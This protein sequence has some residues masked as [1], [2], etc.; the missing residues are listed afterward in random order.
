MS[1]AKSFLRVTQLIG[2]A[3]FAYILASLDLRQVFH[4]LQQ[5]RLEWVAAYAGL[6]AIS[7]TAKGL[8]WNACLKSQKAD[9][10]V[11]RVLGI[12]FVASFVGAVTPG[13]IGEVS[14]IAYLRQENMPLAKAAVSVVLDRLYDIILLCLFGLAGFAYFSSYFLSDV[15]TIILWISLLA[16]GLFFLVALRKRLWSLLKIVVRKTLSVDAYS[17]LADGWESFKSEMS[18]V[19]LSSAPWMMF[20]S[21][22]AYCAFFGQVYALAVGF[23]ISVPFV[24]L[25]LCLALSSLISLL[26]ISIGGLGTRE[27]T[28]IALL[29]KISIPPESAVLIAFTD[30]VVLGL[31]FGALFAL[32]SSLYLKRR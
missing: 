28:F 12:A 1:R 13:R 11:G 21:V 18:I 29:G 7:L 19:L 14:K 27:A 24:Y 30:G 20:Y 26:P 25:S 6:F 10:A 31:A 32:I 23:G 4:Q 3:M 8:R 22:I 17:S 9:V 5:L 15:A 2:V 16:V